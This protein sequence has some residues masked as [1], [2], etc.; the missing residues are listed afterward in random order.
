M[1]LCEQVSHL[2]SVGPPLLVILRLFAHVLPS[3]PK[4]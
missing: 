3:S 1:S 2:T 4:C